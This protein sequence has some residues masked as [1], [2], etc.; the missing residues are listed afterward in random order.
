MRSSFPWALALATTA[1]AAAI[2]PTQAR[3]GTTTK[4]PQATSTPSNACQIAQSAAQSYISTN[5]NASLA[6]IPP[7]VAFNCLST[8]VID[9]QKDLDL[10]NYLEPFVAFQSTLDTLIDPPEGYLLPGVDV[11]GGFGQIR[12]NLLKDVYK[13][14]VEFALDLKRV[15]TQA[16]D[17]HFNYNPSILDLFTFFSRSTLVSVSDDGLS[18]PKVYLQ[19]DFLKSQVD[20]TKV[21]DIKSIG[22]VP[23]TE[24]LEGQSFKV[25]S[26][27]PDSKYNALF[28][29][30]PAT[31]AQ[32][33]GNAFAVRYAGE[34]PDTQ[35]IKF[36][37]DTEY[38]D[39]LVAAVRT[40]LVPF[41]GSPKA[42]H[43]AVELPPTATPTSTSAESPTSLPSTAKP[44]PT[45]IPGYP[46]PIAQHASNWISGYFL[47]GSGYEDTAV[48]AVLSF[49]PSEINSAN[50]TFELAEAKR[51]VEDFLKKSKKAGKTKLI[52]DVQ[53]NGGGFVAAGFQLY[54]QLFPK[55]ADIWDGNRLRAHE[56]LN[57]IG[58]TAQKVSPELLEDFNNAFFDE[59]QKPYKSWQA[60]YGPELIGG[61]NVT[62]LLR[63][64]QSD[65][66]S[67]RSADEQVFE[68]Q[69]IVIVTDGACAS[70]CTI[71]T[72]LLVEEHGVRTVALGGRPREGAMQAVGGVK[73]AQVISFESLQAVIKQTARDAIKANYLDHLRG[74]FYV[75]PD[76]GEPP[77][78]PSLAASGGS[79][80]YRNAYARD[81]VDGFPEQFVYKAANCR[82]FYTS[83]M[84]TDPV[85]IWTRSADIAW[86]RAKCVNG[87][88][89]NSDGTISDDVVPYSKEVIGLN[90]GYKGPGSLLYQ[91]D[92]EPPSPYVRQHTNAKRSIVDNL[93]PSEDF[94]YEYNKLKIGTS[95]AV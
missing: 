32:S 50:G 29:T 18:V 75:L 82:L 83:E 12:A 38:T 89:S 34:A 61:Q 63:Y 81:N 59:A 71:F 73:G 78:L 79:F 58:L 13:S 26:Q 69:N 52:I 44:A 42:I 64:N 72:G 33:G 3:D 86:R 76:I 39:K 7:S 10:I 66:L 77:L 56:A 48:L 2:K 88:T 20:D 70:T 54:D 57:A 87:S 40:D 80:N 55:T 43:S 30:N 16:A 51:V 5:P 1:S 49:A 85:A 47:D 74:A 6:L 9:K 95:H 37:N 45:Q 31:Q 46:L 28:R 24:W 17:G 67:L 8:V 36:T 93:R 25:L 53:A 94:E 92:Y 14:Q 90:P 11:I 15:F 23:I 35:V 84:V 22:G 65:F 91:G 68:T 4:T 41:I 27:D 21:C 62:N 60:L 19:D